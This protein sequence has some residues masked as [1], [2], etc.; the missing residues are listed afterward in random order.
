[1]TI[2]EKILFYGAIAFA[3]LGIFAVGYFVHGSSKAL[4]G[5]V[6]YVPQYQV[7]ADATTN[8]STSVGSLIASVPGV[9]H[10]IDVGTAA[11]GSIISVYDDASTTIVIGTTKLIGTITM[12]N[13]VPLVQ[14]YDAQYQNGLVVDMTG[15]T[16]TVTA[17][18]QVQ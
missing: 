15:A 5:S 17:N 10:T 18:Y 2:G 4:G 11:S 14:T 7:T 13:T 1:M 9:L 3:C 6:L 16:S 12:T 8:S